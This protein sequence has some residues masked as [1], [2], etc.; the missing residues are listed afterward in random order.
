MPWGAPSTPHCPSSS[1]A[2]ALFVAFAGHRQLA[3]LQLTRL[4]SRHRRSPQREQVCSYSA[5][6]PCWE[7][8]WRSGCVPWFVL[9]AHLATVSSWGVR[10]H[11]KETSAEPPQRG[12]LASHPSC[13]ARLPGRQRCFIGRSLPPLSSEDPELIAVW[14]C[15]NSLLQEILPSLL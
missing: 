12:A 2:S 11:P 10:E 3:A 13:Q 14:Q 15:S 8:S 6:G 9:P 1:E 7:P 4:H 5:P